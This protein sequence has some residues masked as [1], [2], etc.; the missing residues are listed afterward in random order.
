MIGTNA[1]DVI[2]VEQEGGLED[3]V[4]ELI[5]RVTGSPYS[6][7]VV[8][9]GQGRFA[10][11]NPAPEGGND[12]RQFD[13]DVLESLLG[14]V[15]SMSL[16]CPLIRSADPGKLATAVAQRWRRGNE[17][18]PGRV[19]FSD[20]A[21][22]GLG[23]L[24]ILQ[25]LPEAVRQRDRCERLRAAAF[26]ALEDG[27]P[28]LFCSEFVHRVLTDAGQRPT[29]P[30]HPIISTAGFPTDEPVHSLMGWMERVEAW[31]R[32]RWKEL[33]GKLAFDDDSFE[34]FEKV[35]RSI[36]DAYENRRTPARLEIANFFTPADFAS[37]PSFELTAS[38]TARDAAWVP[39][40]PPP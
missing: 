30:V 24:R 20:G 38:R 26:W 33:I 13:Q 5:Q 17:P 29:L 23:V 12:I 28:R 34:T 8:V 36:Q 21:L 11:A 3:P 15:K 40:E 22:A 31:L 35:W 27:D 7:T 6:H 9:I 32:S 39:V 19:V 1:G 10:D 37:S 2:L 18:G 16:F 14:E 25:V 4:S